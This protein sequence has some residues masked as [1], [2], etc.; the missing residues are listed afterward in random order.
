MI[1][2]INKIDVGVYP[3]LD[4]EDVVIDIAVGST[5]L[6]PIRIPIAQ[7]ID[8]YIEWSSEMFSKSIAQPNVED[9][10]KLIGILRLAA[11]TLESA[12]A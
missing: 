10:R 8:E 5:D 4:G 7:M 3:F 6:E 12:I 9:A 2:T 11:H 1:R